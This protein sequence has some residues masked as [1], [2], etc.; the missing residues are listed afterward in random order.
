[1]P[2]GA[3]RFDHICNEHYHAKCVKCGRVFD[4][5]MDFIS[6]LEKNIKDTLGFEIAEYDII[7]KDTS[8]IESI[9]ISCHS[10]YIN[11]G[12]KISTIESSA[13]AE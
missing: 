13:Q 4:G 3:D 7:I 1:M 2:S 5:E 8:Y 10:C 6:D 9:E 11:N 12:F